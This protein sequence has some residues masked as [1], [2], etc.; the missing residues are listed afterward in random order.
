MDIKKIRLSLVAAVAAALLLLDLGTG[1]QA[2]QS[3]GAGGTASN[4]TFFLTSVGS[5]KGAD[6]AGLEGADRHCQLLAQAV[7]AGNRSWRALI[8]ARRR[9][10]ASRRSTRATASGADRGRTPREW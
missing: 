7:G 6:L 3:G 9:P 4:M 1:A 2:Q 8:S 10:A 5:G